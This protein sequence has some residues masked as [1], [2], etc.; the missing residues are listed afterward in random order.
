MKVDLNNTE[1]IRT[2]YDFT[3]RTIHNLC[4]NETYIVPSGTMDYAAYAGMLLLLA[5]FAAL[6]SLLVITIFKDLFGGYRW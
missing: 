1:C 2:K 5:I 3:E 6:V 4:T